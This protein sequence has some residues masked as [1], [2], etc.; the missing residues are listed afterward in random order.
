MTKAMK[1][2]VCGLALDKHLADMFEPYE[3]PLENYNFC[4]TMLYTML[5]TEVITPA[6]FDNGVNNA[7]VK[8]A[9]AV[10]IKKGD[11]NNG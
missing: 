5:I 2:Y 10:Q 3:D 4:E 8:Y 11:K 7:R 1:K 6:E 9:E